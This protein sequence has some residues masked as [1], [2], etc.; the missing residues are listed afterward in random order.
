MPFHRLLR[1]AAGAALACAVSSSA[2]ARAYP[3]VRF[4]AGFPAAGANDV[5]TRPMAQWLSAPPDQVVSL[6]ARL[7]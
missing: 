7:S 1:L 3:T 5:L 6:G 4:L 2:W